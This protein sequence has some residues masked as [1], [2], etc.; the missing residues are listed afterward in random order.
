M[1]SF[2]FF[3]ITQMN[4]YTRTCEHTLL[5]NKCLVGTLLRRTMSEKY[6]A[7]KSIS[8]IENTP[9]ITGVLE[10]AEPIWVRVLPS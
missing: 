3:H 1:L 2:H 7:K 5:G 6:S 9:G 4:K 8:V 10:I